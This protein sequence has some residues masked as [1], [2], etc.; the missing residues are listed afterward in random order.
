M[1]INHILIFIKEFQFLRR[2]ID[3][4]EDTFYNNYEYD[5][6]FIRILNVI[7]VLT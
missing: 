3:E 6:K 7:G 2:Y 5:V 1:M 4:N